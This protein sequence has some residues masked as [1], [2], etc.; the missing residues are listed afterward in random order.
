M[1]AISQS[2]NVRV[3]SQAAVVITSTSAT[4]TLWMLLACGAF[5]VGLRQGRLNSQ[6][7][8]C[9]SNMQ[10]PTPYL[11]SPDYPYLIFDMLMPFLNYLH[12][13]EGLILKGST[14]GLLCNQITICVLVAPPHGYRSVKNIIHLE[15]NCFSLS[16]WGLHE[17]SSLCIPDSQ[18]GPCSIAHNG[19]SARVCGLLLPALLYFDFRYM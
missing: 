10:Q 4:F 1:L 18:L 9:D 6:G 19:F 3:A 16:L 14:S 15:A 17:G 8:P 2:E 11:E 13:T 5:R 7:Q 12:T